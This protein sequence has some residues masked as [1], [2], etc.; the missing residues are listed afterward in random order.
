MMRHLYSL[1]VALLLPLALARLGWKGR[2]QP[3]YRER[4]LER[5]GWVPHLPYKPRLWVHA[6][7]VGET[8]AAAPLVRAWQQRHPDW[9][10]L[11]TTTTPTGSAQVR[12]LFGQTVEHCYLPFDLP[13]CARRFLRRCQ[14]SLSI[15]METE[16]WPN[17]Y[18]ACHQAG[19][20][21][22]MANA[23]LS[24]T[25]F[26]SYRRLRW[27]VQPTLR[28]VNRIAARGSEDATRFVALGADATSVEALG[29][30]KFD[31]EV[32]AKA[33]LHGATWR[34][35]WGSQRPVWIAASTHP[36]EEEQVLQAHQ[37]LLAEQPQAVLVLAPRHP[38]RTQDVAKLVQSTSLNC[39][40]RSSISGSVPSTENTPATDLNILLVDTL[41]ELMTFYAASD[42]AFVGGS[43]VPTGGH[44][45]LEPLTLGKPVVSGAQVFNF[46]EVYAELQA[47]GGVAMVS[48]SQELAQQVAT[49]L[50]DPAHRRLAPKVTQWLQTNQGSTARLVERAEELAGLRSVSAPPAPLWPRA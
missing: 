7:S 21:L 33:A 15:V 41:G 28:Q 34:Q 27:L 43:L 48:S 30:L 9:A 45:P 10:I 12:Q 38:N 4:W 20:Q 36:G 1:V 32:P 29:N 14:P 42:V 31:L 11:I 2:S 47:L 18:A 37:A 6:V 3:A 25:S 8:V 35:W 40:L 44:N 39:T 22:L 19:L 16:I 26:K 5:L 49:L 23:R 24:D 50:Q 46:R 13:G 17:L